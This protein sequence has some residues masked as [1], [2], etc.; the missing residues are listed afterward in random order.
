MV[1]GAE[2]VVVVAVWLL[3]TIQVLVVPLFVVA[4]GVVVDVAVLHL[5]EVVADRSFVRRH[6]NRARH[7]LG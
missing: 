6:L 7:R 4:V 3:L 1:V 5:L 2:P